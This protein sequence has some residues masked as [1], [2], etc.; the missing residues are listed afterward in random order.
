MFRVLSILPSIFIGLVF[1]S[2]LINAI[3][4]R[5]FWEKFES[6][7]AKEGTIKNIFHG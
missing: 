2:G 3:N 6:W 4:T 7:K 5:L 1:I